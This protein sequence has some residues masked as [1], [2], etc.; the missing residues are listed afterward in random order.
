[1]DVFYS[2]QT[3][4]YDIITKHKYESFSVSLLYNDY[5]KA[6]LHFLLKFIPLWVT[7]NHITVFG[8]LFST[9]VHLLSIT[10]FFL[11]R[12]NVVIPFVSLKLIIFLTILGHIIAFFGDNLDGCLA[13][14]RRLTSVVGEL[15]DHSFDIYLQ[16]LMLYNIFIALSPHTTYLS[17]YFLLSIQTVFMTM[18]M[19]SYIRGVFEEG[20]VGHIEESILILIGLI[21]SLSLHPNRSEIGYAR[22]IVFSGLIA[23]L[24]AV[25]FAVIHILQGLKECSNK[26]IYNINFL[27]GYM[28]V[29]FFVIWRESIKGG[30][31]LKFYF[32]LLQEIITVFFVSFCFILTV[33]TKSKTDKFLIKNPMLYFLLG[34]FVVNHFIDNKFIIG[35]S[36]LM[37]YVLIIIQ[38][39]LVINKLN[40][41]SGKS[42]FNCGKEEKCE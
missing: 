4:D 37:S 7:P 38:F 26:K 35:A 32:M 8:F 20:Y 21:Y 31:T 15:L 3:K 19:N 27:F 2:I 18:H 5:F 40:E 23:V 17:I 36:C 30:F 16:S 42:L 12:S 39:S 14:T 13:R 33:Q 24:V 34:I 10:A 6:L 41:F 22:L 25:G 1:M 11:Y 9:F 28:V 29:L